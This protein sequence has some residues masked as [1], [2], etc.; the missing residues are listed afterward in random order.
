MS[1]KRF[2]VSTLI[3]AVALP[4]TALVALARPAILTADDPGSQINVRSAPS[5]NASAPSYGLPGDRVEVIREVVGEDGYTWYYVEFNGSRARGWVRG[6]FVR[7]TGSS[8]QPSAWSKTYYCDDYNVT[9]RQ[10][11]NSD[12]YTY[13]ASGTSGNITVKNGS[14]RNTG[15]AWQYTFF[16]G[17]TRY[18]LTDAWASSTDPGNAQLTVYRGNR[19]ILNR[20]CEK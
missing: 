1:L 16:N 2:L 13:S 10:V 12:R 20:F 11:G 19:R 4:A 3:A 17:D 7:L 6:D 5:L 9:L 8:G 15:S 18:Q 14:R